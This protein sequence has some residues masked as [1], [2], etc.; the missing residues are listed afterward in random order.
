LTLLHIEMVYPPADDQLPN[1]STNWTRCRAT[2]SI[3]TNSYPTTLQL[4]P[5]R[6]R[7]TFFPV[8]LSTRLQKKC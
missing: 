6:K 4:F 1:P 8:C 7:G 5:L 2:L 3:K